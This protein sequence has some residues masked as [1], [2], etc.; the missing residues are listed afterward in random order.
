MLPGPASPGERQRVASQPPPLPPGQPRPLCAWKRPPAARRPVL[1]LGCSEEFKTQA[2][3]NGPR[4]GPTAATF[5]TRG[6]NPARKKATKLA[7]RFLLRHFRL[8]SAPR[9]ARSA[10]EASGTR[11]GRATRSAT[12]SPGGT[13]HQMPSLLLPGKL[14]SPRFCRGQPGAGRPLRGLSASRIRCSSPLVLVGPFPSLFKMQKDGE[15]DHRVPVRENPASRSCRRLS[16]SGTQKGLSG[17]LEPPPP[18]LSLG[19]GDLGATFSSPRSQVHFL[20]PG[21]PAPN[22]QPTSAQTPQRA[23]GSREGSGC[24]GRGGLRRRRAGKTGA[25]A[26][27]VFGIVKGGAGWESKVRI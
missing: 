2:N 9:P 7:P 15:L 1:T 27:R 23:Y 18:P 14:C 25:W 16:V 13:G 19:V 22:P 6:A 20:G 26:A 3:A 17:R 24:R 8:G 12:L 11:L 4:W 5:L 10:R 21:I